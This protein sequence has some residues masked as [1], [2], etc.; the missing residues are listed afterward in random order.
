MFWKSQADSIEKGAL[1]ISG[2]AVI[3]SILGILKNTLLA[4]R[5]GAS[6][7]LDI[8]FAAFRVP[9]FL[10]G[11]LVFSSLSSSFMPIFS[12][13]IKNGKDDVWSLV[14]AVFSVFSVLFV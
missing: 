5:F 7:D 4:A 13:A 3:G 2:A 10:Y 12:R 9:D 8:Y 14:S 6:R 11:I 1:V